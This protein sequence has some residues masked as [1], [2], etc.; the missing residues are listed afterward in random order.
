MENNP[1]CDKCPFCKHWALEAEPGAAD[2][3]VCYERPHVMVP[4]QERSIGPG[5]V[6]VAQPGGILPS[7]LPPVIHVHA[8]TNGDYAELR[9]Y[10]IVAIP[11]RTSSRYGCGRFSPRS[12]PRYIFSVLMRQLAAA[13]RFVRGWF[14]NVRPE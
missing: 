9:G 11:T 5:A 3:R 6:L 10:V 14:A 13:I 12:R 2:T 7:L 4:I 8:T 1:H